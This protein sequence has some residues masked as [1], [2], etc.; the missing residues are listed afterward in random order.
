MRGTC[1]PIGPPGRGSELEGPL[2]QPIGTQSAETRRDE[3]AG[4][5]ESETLAPPEEDEGRP[6]GDDHRDLPDLDAEI[7]AKQRGHEPVGR[8]GHLE[9]Y[10]REAE[11]VHQPEG[12]GEA[13]AQPRRPVAAEECEVA[14]REEDQPEHAGKG[15][16]TRAGRPEACEPAEGEEARWLPADDPWQTLEQSQV[17]GTVALWSGEIRLPAERGALRQRIV[18]EEHEALPT[19]F[20]TGALLPQGTRLV[21]ADAVEL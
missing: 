17:T 2:D 18:I 15:Q 19:A 6:E 10:A 3:I 9:Q 11:A 4:E 1:A 21:Y 8:Q 20:G 12:E 16:D 14:G 13:D 7:E 5:G